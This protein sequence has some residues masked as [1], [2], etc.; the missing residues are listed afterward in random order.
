MLS[1]FIPSFF[2]GNR[3]AEKE[4]A[5][6]KSGKKDAFGGF[7]ISPDLG[8]EVADSRRPLPGNI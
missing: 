3:P 5:G 7:S 2:W 6:E 8:F 1:S 4:E